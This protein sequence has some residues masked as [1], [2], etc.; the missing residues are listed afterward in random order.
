MRIA[1]PLF[2][3]V[4]KFLLEDYKIAIGFVSRLLGV[5]VIAVEIKAQETIFKTSKGLKVMRLDFNI[6]V[7]T[8]AA[9]FR[10]VLLE[11]QKA[12]SG[13]RIRRFR[14]YIGMHYWHPD[15]VPTPKGTLKEEELPITTVYIL[16]FQIDP[17]KAAI[18]HTNRLYTDVIENKPLDKSHKYLE[19]LTH[20]SLMIQ[21][22]RLK[23]EI[24]SDIEQAVD[25]F[26]EAKYKTSDNSVL[27][28]TG[29]T[30]DPWIEMVVNR[31]A[32]ALA[33]DDIL[34]SMIMQRAWMEQ[35]AEAERSI[36]EARI[37]KLEVQAE[38]TAKEAERTAKEAERTAKEAERT[39]KEVERT[40]KEAALLKIEKERKAKEKA[41]LQ[42][43][44]LKKQLEEAL[45]KSSNK[46]GNP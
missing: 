42:I 24:H 26:N 37:A 29:D 12:R 35:E 14:S 25:V 40:A 44:Q 32:L 8:K 45:K 20:D 17:I 5:E 10:K 31:L 3:A 22:P 41:Y 9:K 23:M 7:E 46:N 28:Y 21:T 19:T 33:D 1:N 13:F 27:D 36:E 34:R 15:I 18:V 43:E 39:A 38:R 2:D 11:V 30:T 6:L 16:G 4:V